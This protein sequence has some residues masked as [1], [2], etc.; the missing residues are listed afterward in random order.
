[1]E[2]TKKFIAIPIKNLIKIKIFELNRNRIDIE[3]NNK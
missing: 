2:I 1:M 3:L